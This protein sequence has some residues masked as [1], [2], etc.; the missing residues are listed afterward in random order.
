M[1]A[2]RSSA[3][4]LHHIKLSSPHRPSPF[5]KEEGR[6]RRD[7]FFS[8]P[9]PKAAASRVGTILGFLEGPSFE[10]LRNFTRV[11]IRAFDPTKDVKIMQPFAN[12]IKQ[13]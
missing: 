11:S 5:Y 10:F 9:N 13:M 3:D 12:I 1:I 8:Y 6:L 2:A 4:V 7:C